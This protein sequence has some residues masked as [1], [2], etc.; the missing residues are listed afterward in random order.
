MTMPIEP[1]RPPRVEP[2]VPSRRVERTSRD[3]EQ[4]RSGGEH[5]R[6]EHPND[7]PETGEE[8]GL[9]VDVLA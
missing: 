5:T 8:P 2:A 9:H 1:V 6:D 4:R 7:E 3:A